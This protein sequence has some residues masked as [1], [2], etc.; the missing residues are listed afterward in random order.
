M[1]WLMKKDGTRLDCRRRLPV[2]HS[3]RA[4]ASTVLDGAVIRA[5]PRFDDNTK[6]QR[7]HDAGTRYTTLFRPLQLAVTRSAGWAASNAQKH[8]TPF[9]LDDKGLG[10]ND[11]RRCG[12]DIAGLEERSMARTPASISA[13][14]PSQQQ[15]IQASLPSSM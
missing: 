15:E 9:A 5:G 6:R 4:S 10:I 12:K 1:L 14:L 11:A 7:R 13:L 3:L 8:T 2:R